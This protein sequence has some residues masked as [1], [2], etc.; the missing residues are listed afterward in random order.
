MMIDLL[1]DICYPCFCNTREIKMS[2]KPKRNDLCPCGSGIKYKYC[3]ISKELKERIV[4]IN[5]VCPK[6]GDGLSV[7]LTNDWMNRVAAIYTPL[8]NFCKDNGLYFF[9]MHSRLGE[10]ESLCEKLKNGTLNINDIMDVYKKNFVKDAILKLLESCIQE[11]D[12]FKKREKFLK[13]A[14]YAHFDGKYTLSVPV[15]FAQLEGI[16]RDIGH[17][18][19]KDSVRSTIHKM[20]WNERMAFSIQDD[21]EYY[22]SFI[23]RLFEGGKAPS[24]FNRNPILHGFGLD[25]PTEENSMILFMSILELRNFLWFDKNIDNLL[26]KYQQ[27]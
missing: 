22:N 2:N 8:K 9:G 25:Y 3:C 15:L 18:E 10:V 14:L 4:P 24:E 1:K 27:K 6:C 19:N 20:N 13:D 11:S 5:Y 17:I 7:N 26:K 23:T 16:L 21:S 12:I